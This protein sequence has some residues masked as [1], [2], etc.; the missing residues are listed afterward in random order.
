M[1]NAR[2]CKGVSQK[3]SLGV[4]FHVLKSLGKCERMNLHTSKWV[5][6]LGMYLNFSFFYYVHLGFTFDLL[7]SLGVRC[8]RS[9]SS[10]AF[11]QYNFY[12]GFIFYQTHGK[13]CFRSQGEGRDGLCGYSIKMGKVLHLCLRP[14][15]FL[16]N[17]HNLPPLKKKK[18]KYSW[19]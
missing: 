11:W 14:F 10:F 12:I 2:V 7:K 17:R 3:W 16:S 4:T 5:P 9:K 15:P 13:G 19:K 18:K 6:H 8:N 1:T